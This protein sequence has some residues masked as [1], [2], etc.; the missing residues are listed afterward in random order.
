MTIY[1]WRCLS[2]GL[3]IVALSILA[4]TGLKVRMP[5]D[6]H[7]WRC[8]TG[9]VFGCLVVQAVIYPAFAR[10][11]GGNEATISACC[12]DWAKMWPVIPAALFFTLGHIFWSVR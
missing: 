10:V 9:F 4:A 11:F 8:L 3:I 2:F 1:A 6:L 7:E 5:A 12:Q